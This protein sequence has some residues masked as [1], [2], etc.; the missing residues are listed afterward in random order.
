MRAEAEILLAKNGSTVP[1][2]KYAGTEFDPFSIVDSCRTIRLVTMPDGAYWVVP[3][4]SEAGMPFKGRS[5]VLTKSQAA[6]LIALRNGA[7]QP[8]L[9]AH[10]GR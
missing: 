2:A 7:G 5:L 10:R 4:Q 3:N 8:S 1:P 6:C 9:S